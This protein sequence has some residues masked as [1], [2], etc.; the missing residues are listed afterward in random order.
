MTNQSEQAKG[1]KETKQPLSIEFLQSKSLSNAGW[2]LGSCHYY[3]GDYSIR[4]MDNGTFWVI[5]NG[6][7]FDIDWQIF[8][9][10]DVNNLCF[11]NLPIN[12]NR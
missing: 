3:F 1:Q 4:A 8:T 2:N 7:I 9:Q 10:D 5:T 6:I 11:N 12:H